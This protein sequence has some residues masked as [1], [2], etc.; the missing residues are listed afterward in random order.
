MRGDAEDAR[1]QLLLE[2]VHH[3]KHD[4]QRRN[5]E[6]DAEHRYK[7]DEGNESVA[8]L[9]A[10]ARAGV[11]QA[12]EEFIWHCLRFPMAK[13]NKGGIVPAAG[14]A[15]DI[16]A[17]A[18]VSPTAAGAARAGLR[19]AFAAAG[20][21]QPGLIRGKLECPT[22]VWP[23]AIHVAARQTL[24]RPLPRPARPQR[25]RLADAGDR[26]G[27]DVRCCGN[28]SWAHFAE[29]AQDRFSHR[30]EARDNLLLSRMQ[31]TNRC[32]GAAAA[33]FAASDEV[34]RA[35][36]R[37]Y[38]GALA[39][40]RS[41][42]GIQGTGFTRMLPAGTT[43][44][45]RRRG[46]RRGLSR[47]PHA[48]ARRARPLQQHPLS[49]ALRRPQP[50]RLRLRHVFRPGARREAMERARDT[51]MPALSGKVTLVQEFGSEV[52]AGFLIYL[53]IY[54]AGTTPDTV[55]ARRAALLGFVYSALPRARHHARHLQRAPGRRT[56]RA[57][58]R[59]PDRPT[60]LLYASAQRS[61][62]RALRR[63]PIR[64][65]SPAATGWLRLSSTPAFEA[66]HASAEPGA[67]PLRRQRRSA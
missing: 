19:R 27:A 5:P 3:R 26:P 24:A 11:A 64:S 37:A 66:D 15:R 6:R 62:A 33:L 51:G 14:R 48:S 32:C 28:T 56:T 13:R 8:P 7:G 60:N 43:G 53:P 31:A 20:R 42:P 29:R 23:S 4:D 65:R 58:R 10:L 67:D 45:A 52:Q 40:D 12:D 22:P 21:W 50:A 2:T 57:L 44:R 9:R 55:D 17:H 35:E 54:A 38:V 63:R 41:L 25:S 39:L 59:P 18:I 47:L 49:G 1:A 36:W 30:A 34:S 46:T 61:P 16:E